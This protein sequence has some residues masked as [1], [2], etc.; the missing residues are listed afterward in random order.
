MSITWSMLHPSVGM[1]NFVDN[2]LSD[3][4]F[5][6]AYGRLMEELGNR[7]LLSKV[8]I[9][10]HVS[11]PLRRRKVGRQMKNKIKWCLEG[12]SGKKPSANETK[13]TKKL[14]RGKFKCANYHEVGHK[15][16]SKCLLN[17]TKKRQILDI[18]HFL[19]LGHIS[20]IF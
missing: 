12:G 11:A 19:S 2:Y 14:V 7:S 20:L 4:K 8:N 3:E 10:F 17:G 15:N 6:K 16:N 9:G 18:S 5:K 1:E 13:K